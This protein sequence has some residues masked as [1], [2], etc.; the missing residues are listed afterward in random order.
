L[1]PNRKRSA[2]GMLRE[3]FGVSERRACG[4]IGQPRS[5]QR[6]VPS[7]H[8]ARLVE[9]LIAFSKA[10]PRYGWRRA[11]KAARRAGWA[12]NDKRVKRLWRKNGEVSP[13]S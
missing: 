5:T 8:E 11:A 4:V 2:V 10:K 6:L 1:T 13:V 9:V 7:D 12:V 3:R